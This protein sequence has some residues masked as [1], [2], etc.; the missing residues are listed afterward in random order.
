MNTPKDEQEHV[1]NNIKVLQEVRKELS[2]AENIELDR[3][4]IEAANKFEKAEHNFLDLAF[5]MGAQEDMTL[6]DAKEFITYLKELRLYQNGLVSLDEVRENPLS[7]IDYILT[8]STHT[9]FFES[10]VVSYSHSGLEGSVDYTKY[11][12]FVD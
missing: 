1:R 7:W 10:R 6:A 4:I 12:D 8:G 9:N 3:F 11:L 2:E 5:E